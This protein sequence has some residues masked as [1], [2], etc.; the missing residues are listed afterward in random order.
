MTADR[1]AVPQ[2]TPNKVAIAIA[3]REAFKEYRRGKPVAFQL[4]RR[5]PRD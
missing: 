4:P 1:P 3:A 5:M 2:E